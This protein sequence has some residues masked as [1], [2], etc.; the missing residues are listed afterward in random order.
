MKKVVR[1]KVYLS[2]AG[3]SGLEDGQ[4]GK[5]GSVEGGTVGCLNCDFCD[6]MIYRIEERWV[7]GWRDGR[8]EGGISNCLKRDL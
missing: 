2:E 7:E 3:F 8:L 5:I 1:R 4:D 6:S